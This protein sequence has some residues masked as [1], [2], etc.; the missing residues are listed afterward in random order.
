MGGNRLV[1]LDI[2][3]ADLLA[4]AASTQRAVSDRVEG[5]FPFVS[6]VW[7]NNYVSHILIVVFF[8]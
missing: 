2:D 7:T 6:A 8:C 3:R 1:A 4:Q 5:F